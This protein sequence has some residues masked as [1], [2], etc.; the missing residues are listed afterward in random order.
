MCIRT[1]YQN[2]LEML[3]EQLLLTTV[4]LSSL[5]H[6][7]AVKVMEIVF[8]LKGYRQKHLINFATQLFTMIIITNIS[9]IIQKS[10]SGSFYNF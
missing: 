10:I 5:Y 3:K 6:K 7:T 4:G 2:F 1:N 9:Y 8:I